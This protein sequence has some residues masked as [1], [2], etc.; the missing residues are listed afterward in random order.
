MQLVEFQGQVGTK[1]AFA[2]RARDLDGNFRRLKPLPNGQYGI[3]E[4]LHGWSL[5]IFPAYPETV[6]A[7]AV[8]FLSYGADG[9]QWLDGTS[10]TGGISASGITANAH[11]VADGAD[12]TTWAYPPS[13]EPDWRLVERC[14]GKQMYVWGTDWFDPE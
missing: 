4:T 13:G 8:H 14:D 6:S 9:L 5:D 1:D 12:N 10:L 11:L 3:N 7:S 2:I